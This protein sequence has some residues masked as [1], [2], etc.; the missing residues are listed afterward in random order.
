MDRRLLV[1][2]A[3][4]GALHLLTGHVWAEKVLMYDEERGIIMVDKDS[5]PP[6]R[7]QGASET[8]S[9]GSRLG[10]ASSAKNRPSKDVHIGR[11][12]DPHGLYFQSGL[13]YFKSGDFENALRNFLF[14]DSLA[15]NP[16]YKL[17]IGKTY[18]QLDKSGL[19]LG[20]MQG[21]ADE[22]PESD[23]A[24]DALF[25]IA[26]FHQVHDDYDRAMEL[27][28]RLAE[29]Y[30]FGVSYSSKEP[31]REVAREQRS[32]MRAEVISSMSILGHQ[33]Q[34]LKDLFTTFQ[35][36]A[37]LPATGNGDP[38]TIRAMKAAIEQRQFE[39][40]V[41]ATKKEQYQR[42]AAYGWVIFG[43]FVL[44]LLSV[45]IAGAKLRSLRNHLKELGRSLHDLDTA[46]L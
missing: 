30:P 17:W 40:S 45:I 26:F 5:P 7:E 1:F 36:A 2:C 8:P 16:V 10:P 20:I 34:E 29:Q 39:D 21:I 27:Y 24:D 38:E 33:G 32:R 44:N 25:E 37:R 11:K 6:S 15:S 46:S 42:H 19:M 23:V 9:L 18:R 22:F 3:L 35:L 43:F 14:A 12:K 41:R 28:T 13:E 4:F 31:F